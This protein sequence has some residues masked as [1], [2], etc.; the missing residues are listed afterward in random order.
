MF[1]M[2]MLHWYE[3]CR[4]LWIE[5]GPKWDEALLNLS[6]DFFDALMVS[7]NS[8]LLQ[9]QMFLCYHVHDLNVLLCYRWFMTHARKVDFYICKLYHHDFQLI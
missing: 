1:Y 7:Y 5:G 8:L 6:E 2:H 9:I 4:Q 3:G